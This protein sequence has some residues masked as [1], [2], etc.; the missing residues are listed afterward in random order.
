MN[1]GWKIFIVYSLFVLMTLGMTFYFMGQEVHL[2]S[3]DYYKQEIAYQDQIDRI[4]NTRALS[5]DLKIDIQRDIAVISIQFPGELVGTPLD[6]EILLYR[7]SDARLDHT[8]PIRINDSGVQ[9]ISSSDLVKGL[10][11]LK[12]IW[13]AS[14]KDYYDEKVIVL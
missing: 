13:S 9:E 4:S 5:E 8:Y 10:W 1:W 3:E 7:P 14:G 12:I 11:R 2:V 6:G